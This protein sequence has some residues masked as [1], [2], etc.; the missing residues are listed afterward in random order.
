[1]S[2]RSRLILLSG[3][4]TSLATAL[5]ASTAQALDVPVLVADADAPV[6][7]A[8]AHALVEGLAPLL[9]GTSAVPHEVWSRLPGLDQ[10]TVLLTAADAMAQGDVVVDA[11]DLASA[12]RLVGLPELALR[13]LDAA[14]TPAV[15]SARASGAPFEALSTTRAALIRV[16]RALR[17]PQTSMRLACRAGDADRAL[18]AARTLSILGI[19]VDGV[20]VV[21]R[22]G[23][24]AAAR[25]SAQRLQRRGLTAWSTGRRLR[26]APRDI[27]PFTV[28]PAPHP[29][30]DADLTAVETADGYRLVVPAA[31]DAVGL[32]GSDLVIRAG[33]A[34]RW[35]PL[36]SVLTRCLVTGA[37]RRGG[38]VEIDFVRDPARWPVAS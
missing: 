3:T 10:L 14:M 27:D 37:A 30:A 16:A 2:S 17:A 15:A 19:Q 11:G 12:I 26:P 29:L 28:L 21:R 4:T 9:T 7:P 33:R 32:D 18:Q 35:C 23:D 22:D 38:G 6:H 34:L 25:S 1:M 36:P 13:M 20:A 5:A 24:R 8:V 31:V